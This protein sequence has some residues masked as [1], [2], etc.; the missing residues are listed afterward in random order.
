V[1]PTVN[2]EGYVANRQNFYSVPWQRIG[3]LLPLR[4]TE[5]E[6]SL[7]CSVQA[8]RDIAQALAIGEVREGHGQ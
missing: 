7:L 5:Q 1:Y 6:C 4:I 3:Q 8:G 2:C